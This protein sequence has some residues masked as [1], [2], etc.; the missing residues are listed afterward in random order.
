MSISSVKTGAVGVSLLAGN[1]YYDPAAT[2][3][4]QRVTAT[5]SE[6]TITFS[7]IPQNYKHLQIRMMAERNTTASHN[8]AVDVRLN[9]ATGT[10]GAY[11]NLYGDGASVVASGTASTQDLR[12]FFLFTTAGTANTSI[13]GTG[14]VDIHD[15]T[16][17]T[18]NKTIRSIG[19]FDSNGA[20]RIYLSSGLYA[21]TTPVTSV[22][23]Y[24]AGDTVRSGSTFALYGMVG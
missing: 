1:P 17:S 3:L 22:A 15:Y 11:H 14:I 19:G 21:V 12:Q 18:K 10:S 6:T 9:G 8:F 23:L 2:F 13:Y 5:G 20:G 4:I 16:S 24:F 7:S